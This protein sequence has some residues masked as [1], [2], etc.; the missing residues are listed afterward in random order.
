MRKQLMPDQAEALDRFASQW[1]R[2][3]RP[4]WRHVLRSCW[5]TGRWPEWVS[6]DD[7]ARLQ[8]VRNTLGPS[9]LAKYVP[10]WGKARAT[11]RPWTAR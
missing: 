10:Q 9:W 8:R 1:G 6:D 4:A 2:S 7:R 3:R 5:A 11:E